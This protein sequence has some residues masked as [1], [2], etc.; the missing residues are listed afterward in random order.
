MRIA[1]YNILDGGLGRLDPIAE[2]LKVIDADVVAVIEANDVDGI[3]YIAG[4][5]GYEY[6]VAESPTTR[7]HVAMLSRLPIVEAVNLGVRRR[8]LSRAALRATVGDGD[9]AM[10]WLVVHLDSGLGADVEANRVREMQW[11]LADLAD[12]GLRRVIAGDL[13]TNAPYHPVDTDA[14]TPDVQQRLADDPTLIRHDLVDALVADG[15]VDA[16]AR[17][18]PGNPVH[19]FSTAYASTRLDYIFVDDALAGRVIDAGVET[20]GFAPYCS[21]HFPLWADL[22]PVRGT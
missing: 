2:T 18:H 13:N 21:D 1:T 6:V 16:Y 19:T 14:A 8:Q 20:R 3:A 17:V 11:L 7:F 12:D 9:E 22:A 4:K 15:W 10:Q 5:L